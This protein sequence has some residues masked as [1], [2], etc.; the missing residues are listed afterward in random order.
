MADLGELLISACGNGSLERVKDLVLQL[1]APIDY[2]PEG[3]SP[4]V[5]ACAQ[6]HM[7]I[8]DFLIEQGADLN[9]TTSDGWT[10]AFAA[11]TNGHHSVLEKLLEHGANTRR[12]EKS[13]L[14][15]LE[16]AHEKNDSRSIALIKKYNAWQVDDD[17]SVQHFA[18]KGGF[19]ISRIFNFESMTVMTIVENKARNAV[20]HS[21]QHFSEPSVD[22]ALLMKAKDKLLERH[23]N[24]LDE[25]HFKQS[26]QRPVRTQM[27]RVSKRPVRA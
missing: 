4:L 24:A 5:K 15:P 16:K 6:N 19:S 21:E 13:V 12:P 10:P 17:N 27:H 14:C 8:V 11:V 2:A 22:F 9:V 26:L 20:S 1:D 7:D 23:P 18:D 3:W 25:S